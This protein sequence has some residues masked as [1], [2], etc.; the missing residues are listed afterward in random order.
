MKALVFIGY[1]VFK[2]DLSLIIQN[3]LLILLNY[4]LILNIQNTDLL[5]L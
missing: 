4:Y 1:G 5:L 3:F 2:L